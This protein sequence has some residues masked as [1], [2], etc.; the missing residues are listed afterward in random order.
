M[1]RESTETRWISWREASELTGIPMPTIEH[2]G[3]VG[4]IARREAHGN[5]PTLDRDSVLEWADSYRAQKVEAEKRGRPRPKS[6]KT[7]KRIVRHFRETRDEEW[8]TA[9]EAAEVLGTCEDTVRRMA[10]NGKLASRRER[11]WLVHRDAV[12]AY[13]AE[14]ARWITWVEAARLI[15]APR[16]VVESWIRDGRLRTRNVP[17]A[18][19]SV[20]RLSAEALAVEWRAIVTEREARRRAR[21]RSLDARRRLASPP[22][23]GEMWLTPSQAA[24]LLGCSQQAVRNRVHSERLPGIQR[25]G[26]IWLRRRDV[27][28]AARAAAFPSS[29][30]S[31]KT[32]SNGIES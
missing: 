5:W 32:G 25:A 10:R 23:D 9:A 11:L 27:E 13:A 2:A 4:R 6:R 1:T 29:A 18:K 12:A 26:R 15:G 21:Q 16:H 17:R 7:S 8:L 30:R 22:A 20:E 28:Q 19:P 14:E 24:E 31:I 3:R